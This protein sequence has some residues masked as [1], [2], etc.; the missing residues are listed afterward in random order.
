MHIGSPKGVALLEFEAVGEE[1]PEE[2]PPAGRN[3]RQRT[4]TERLT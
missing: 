3:Q 2:I 1:I 4:G